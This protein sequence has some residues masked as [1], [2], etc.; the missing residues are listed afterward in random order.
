MKLGFLVCFLLIYLIFLLNFLTDIQ[1]SVC[2]LLLALTSPSKPV[3]TAAVEVLLT[4]S[5]KLDG[6]FST[7]LKELTERRNEIIA[8]S[9]YVNFKKRNHS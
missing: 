5:E 4:V 3:R 7:L 1:Y 2:C 6:Q 9:E 8:D